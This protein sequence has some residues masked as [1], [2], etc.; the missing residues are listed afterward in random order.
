MNGALSLLMT[1]SSQ[2]LTLWILELHSLIETGG[3]YC[4]IV[5]MSSSMSHFIIHSSNTRLFQNKTSAVLLLAQV[6]F[7]DQVSDLGEFTQPVLLLNV[8]A[9]SRH[10]C[11]PFA[12]ILQDAMCHLASRT[13]PTGFF[14]SPPS[15]NL[16]HSNCPSTNWL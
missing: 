8:P 4:D 16:F 6:Q 14:S 7:Q 11:S 1:S 9:H 15:N 10:T 13:L 5:D 3:L 12:M 2:S